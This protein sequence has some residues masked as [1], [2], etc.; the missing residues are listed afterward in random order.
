[1]AFKVRTVEL[2]ATGRE[3]VRDRNLAGPVVTVGRASEND[4]HLP[5]LAVEP[6]HATITEMEGG[7]V[8]VS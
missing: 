7:R 4:I 3:I 6:H 5:D 1:M 8:S 2:T